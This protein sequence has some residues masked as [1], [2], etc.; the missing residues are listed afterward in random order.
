MGLAIRIR[1]AL[2]QT[3]PEAPRRILALVRRQLRDS[4]AGTASRFAFRSA[5]RPEWPVAGALEQPIRQGPYWE[6]K[7]V[8]LQQGCAL[9]DGVTIA[10]GQ[11]FSFWT[12]VGRPAAGRGFA[13]G[14]GIRGDAAQGDIGGGLCQLSGIVYELGL[15]CG[16]EIIERHPHSR[17][18]YQ[19]ESERFAQL[20]MDATVVWPWKDLRLENRS[21]QALTLRLKVEGLTLRAEVCGENAIPVPEIK[22]DRSDYPDLREVTVVRDGVVVSQDR[23]A[24]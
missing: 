2:R 16:L 21:G 7:L 5:D 9:I 19:N 6:G 13:E 23:Y 18:L 20:G 14:R 8:N 15:R 24:I 3:L 12:L 1:K 22:V 11:V 17:D 4:V 10:P